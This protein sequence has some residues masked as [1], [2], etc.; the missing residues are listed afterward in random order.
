MKVISQVS[1]DLPVGRVVDRFQA[2]DARL[3]GGI[4]FLHVSEEME[5]L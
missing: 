3:Q 1:D 5:L 2:D 4:M